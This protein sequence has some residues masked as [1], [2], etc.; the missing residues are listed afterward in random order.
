MATFGRPRTDFFR[1]LVAPRAIQ[2]SLIFRLGP[3]STAELSQSTPG[4]SEL[5]FW[6]IFMTFGVPFWLHFSTFSKNRKT[7]KS[8]TLTT[9]WKVFHLAKPLIFRW[10][11]H[12]FSCFFR[13]P[14]RRAFLEVPS[15]GLS[16]KG[17]F[18][19]HF[20]FSVG[21]EIDP[22]APLF[23]LK[24]RFWVTRQSGETV[25]GPTLAR[26]ATQSHPK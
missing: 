13:N 26:S 7:M 12:Y 17:R 6:S 19:C 3:K 9:F 11:F 1:F 4:R 16:S 5:D 24:C 14:S 15:A 20:G 18:W 10:I 2:K 25:L 21:L 23:R 8:M 22:W